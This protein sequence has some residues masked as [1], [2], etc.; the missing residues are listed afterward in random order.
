MSDRDQKP[1]NPRHCFELMF[2][3]RHAEVIYRYVD[4]CL[5]KYPD[6]CFDVQSSQYTVYERSQETWHDLRQAYSVTLL[7]Y[8]FNLIL[9]FSIT[10][11][12]L[13]WFRLKQTSRGPHCSYLFFKR[14]GGSLRLAGCPSKMLCC[15]LSWNEI[16]CTYERRFNRDVYTY[17]QASQK[18]ISTP[19][20]FYLCGHHRVLQTC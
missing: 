11:E 8:T 15:S 16:M 17:T 19:I 20:R 2:T 12:L 3:L 10:Q 9:I 7:Y 5:T 1:L 13:A 6:V 14:V 18:E 4:K